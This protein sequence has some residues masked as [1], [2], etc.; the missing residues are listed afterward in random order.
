MR[1]LARRAL[2]AAIVLSPSLLSAQG[3]TVQSVVDMRFEG[4]LG[5][6]MNMAARMSGT[7]MH[8]IATTTS[9]QGHRLRTETATSATVIDLDAE[10]VTEIDHKKKSYSS[11]T[12]AEMMAA[13]E[14]ARAS[15]EESRAKEQA[16]AQKK[17]ASTPPENKD[18][19]KVKYH[20]AVDRTGQRQK[21]AG[22]DAER[23]FV[24]ITLEAEATPEGK[25]T[26]QVGSMVFLLD[27][28]LAVNAPQKA[29]YAEFYKLYSQKLGR[30]FRGQVQGM[31]AAFASDARL[32]DGFEAAGKEL[33]KLQGVA[34]RSTTH[35]ALVPVNTAFDRKL[36]LDGAAT[37]A[38]AAKADEANKDDKPKKGFGG[39]MGA[40]KKTAEDM[41]KQ[42]DSRDAN[43]D[44]PP[45][46][47]TLMVLVD[48]VK[49]ISTGSVPAEMF[50]APADYKE[51]KR[52]AP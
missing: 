9:L 17:G 4:G 51:V 7:S 44:A 5:T 26:E 22:Y 34:L 19:V 25:K 6:I 36:A 15:A 8:D 43:K 40:L 39:L 21:V 2:A 14:Q 37:S 18:S 12:F 1:T 27:Q 3:L 47:M 20:V 38:A 42:Q 52:K 31:Q 23:V 16:K 46:Q 50:A 11:F 32:K 33:Q 41:S 49:S 28:W 29:A 48:E 45:K 10:R 30:E 24:T 35:V 13:M